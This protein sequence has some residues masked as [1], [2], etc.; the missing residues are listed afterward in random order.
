VVGFG[1]P[2]HTDD[3]YVT[4]DVNSGPCPHVCDETSPAIHD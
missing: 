2:D 4:S 1:S 3:I